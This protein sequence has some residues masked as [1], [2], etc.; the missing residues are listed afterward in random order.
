MSLT[1][2]LAHAW[3]DRWDRQ[4]E[5]Y[6]PDR[7]L[8]FA[9]I[10]DAVAANADRPDPLVL[11]VACGPGSLG[12]RIRERLPQARV[13]GIDADPVLLELARTAYGFELV[14]HNLADPAWAAGLP[15]GRIDAI[16]STTA[17]HWLY[18][19]QLAALYRQAA[20]LLRPG[21]ILLN[22]DDMATHATDIDQLHEAIGTRQL[23]REGV[24]D[25]ENWAD[26]W[27]AIAAE[28]E[29]ATAVAEREVRRWEHPSDSGTTYEEHLNL[30]RAAGFRTAGSIWQ[31]GRRHIVAAVN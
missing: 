9:V 27:S 4:Q 20:Q 18:S 30:L 7:E 6:L 16:V 1:P 5:G 19:D 28:P 26:W 13:I 12:A 11:D 23:E 3:I 25:R 2:T 29:L 22:G 24:T 21:G 10:A 17:L 15:A 31:Y 8:M 14:D